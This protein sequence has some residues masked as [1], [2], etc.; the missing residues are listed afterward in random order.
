MGAAGF[1]LL[2]SLEFHCLRRIRTAAAGSLSVCL[3]L[4]KRTR[5]TCVAQVNCGREECT[6]VNKNRLKHCYAR[7]RGR[8]GSNIF[9]L[10]VRRINNFLPGATHLV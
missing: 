7:G 8:V 10:V 9:Y 2:F 5:K 6:Q 1:S 4:R 3:P